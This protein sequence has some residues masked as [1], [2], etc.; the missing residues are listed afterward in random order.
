MGPKP[1]VVLVEDDAAARLLVSVALETL[2]IELIECSRVAEAAEALARGGVRLLMTD[3]TLHG[4][5]SGLELLEW[6]SREPALLGAARVAVFSG[7]T[8]RRTRQTLE[9]LRVWRIL[10]KPASL[11]SLEGCVRDALADDT[12]V[13]ALRPAAPDWPDGLERHDRLPANEAD[14]I[15]WNFEGNVQLFTA[16]KRVCLAQFAFDVRT[17]DEACNNADAEALRRMAHNLKTVLQSLGHPGLGQ[18]ARLIEER[19]AAG[20][21][22]A[23]VPAWQALRV[24]LLRLA[25]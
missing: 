14:A 2:D 22:D 9:R 21:L 19:A 15:A 1:R 16:F 4:E 11:A 20:E 18:Q 13:L 12:P 7:F 25:E 8:D 24:Q 5:M 10:E 23:A 17:A 6:L 3:L